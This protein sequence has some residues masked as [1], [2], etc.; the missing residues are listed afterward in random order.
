MKSTEGEPAAGAA[1]LWLPVDPF[2]DQPAEVLPVDRFDDE[3]AVADEGLP[4]DPF[5]VPPRY[6]V[7]SRLLAICN[8]IFILAASVSSSYLL[9]IIT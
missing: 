9:Q 7:C 1:E 6:M 8:V 4:V 2:H 5:A 3:Q